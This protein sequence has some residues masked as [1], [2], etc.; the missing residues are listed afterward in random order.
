MLS[1]GSCRAGQIFPPL[2]EEKNFLAPSLRRFF[3]N[4]SSQ[5]YTAGIPEV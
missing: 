5:I 1:A 4:V 3:K 2:G